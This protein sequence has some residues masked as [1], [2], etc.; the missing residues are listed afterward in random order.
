MREMPAAALQSASR[1]LVERAGE[2]L[3][4]ERKA[5]DVRHMEGTIRYDERRN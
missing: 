4:I 3:R 5:T 2:L 1:R